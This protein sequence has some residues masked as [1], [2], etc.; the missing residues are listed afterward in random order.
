MLRIQLGDTFITADEEKLPQPPFE[1]GWIHI[2]AVIGCP[3]SKYAVPDALVACAPDAAPIAM[4][5]VSAPAA[6]AFL[7]FLTIFIRF[8]ILNYRSALE[9]Q[10]LF[11][12]DM[13]IEH[14]LHPEPIARN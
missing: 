14:V 9:F 12:S 4:S 1:T 6:T 5:V 13:N 3:L 10:P 11:W 7:T 2:F 8:P